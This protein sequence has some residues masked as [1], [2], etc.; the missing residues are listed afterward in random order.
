MDEKIVDIKPAQDKQDMELSVFGLSLTAM[1][2]AEINKAFLRYTKKRQEML[3]KQAEIQE[4]VEEMI[5]EYNATQSAF[6]SIVMQ[7]WI[8]MVIEHKPSSIKKE[9]IP[10][11]IEQA[12]G[13]L[14]IILG[15]DGKIKPTLRGDIVGKEG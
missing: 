1:E 11:I 13:K 15:E 12:T 9:G 7:K 5:H 6:E 4:I 10:N 3:V 2:V 8:D 14:S